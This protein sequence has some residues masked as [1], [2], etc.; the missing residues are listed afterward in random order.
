MVIRSQVNESRYKE[1]EDCIEPVFNIYTLL[2]PNQTPIFLFALPLCSQK[3]I[4][5][6]KNIAGTSPL[7][8]PPKLRLRI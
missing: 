8:H 7:L 1:R 6:Y 4:L 3:N 2:S 5:R